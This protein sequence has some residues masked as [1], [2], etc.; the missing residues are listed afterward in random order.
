M[1]F[2]FSSRSVSAYHISVTISERSHEYDYHDHDFLELAYVLEGTAIHYVNGISCQITKGDYIII[3]Y[4]VMHKYEKTSDNSS[5]KIMNCIFSPRIID[6]TL[7]NCRQFSE[8]INHYLINFNIQNLK[9]KPTQFIYHDSDGEI[10]SLLTRMHAEY[11]TKKMGY[12]EILRSRLIELLI[13]TMRK[14]QLPDSESIDNSMVQHV[15]RYIQKHYPEKLSLNEIT[16]KYNFSLSQKGYIFKKET[17]MNFQDY[18]QNIRI[19]ES[20]RL[21]INTN[22]TITEVSSAVGYSDVKF[23]NELFKR[24][25]GITPGQYRKMQK[26]G[27]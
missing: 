21:L 17:G 13:C 2:K 12:Q 7:K 8:V 24:Y 1:P 22:L 5:F 25:L 27:T 3:D 16:S 23:F 26:L 14:I 6:E 4:N 11:N 9:T 10:L 18:V 15:I 20:C 19:N